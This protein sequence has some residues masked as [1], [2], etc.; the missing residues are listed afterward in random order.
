VNVWLI[1]GSPANPHMGGQPWPVVAFSDCERAAEA[2][3]ILREGGIAWA[4]YHDDSDAPDPWDDDYA[5][6]AKLDP[7][8]NDLTYDPPTY[9]AVPIALDP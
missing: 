7:S 9:A 5:P 2:A 4:R 3:G 1:V 8:W 6:P